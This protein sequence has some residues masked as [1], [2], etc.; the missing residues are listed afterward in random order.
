MSSAGLVGL[1]LPMM[2]QLMTWECLLLIEIVLVLDCSCFCPMSLYLARWG[3]F[4]YVWE[5]CSLIS[6]KCW[7]W[8]PRKLHDCWCVRQIVQQ[9]VLQQNLKN[10]EMCECW[11]QHLPRPGEA[12]RCWLPALLLLRVRVYFQVTAC[13]SRSLSTCLAGPVCPDFPIYS[14]GRG[15]SRP[16]SIFSGLAAFLSS[17]HTRHVQWA[18][19]YRTCL[20]T[21]ATIA[22][23]NNNTDCTALELHTRL[24]L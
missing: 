17:R 7:C 11:R 24:W 3:L 19:R 21:C 20:S 9:Y 18:H 2:Q 16:P 1:E 14:I 12:R 22:I 6:G 15:R 10:I 4:L 5:T 13:M 23:A 8:T